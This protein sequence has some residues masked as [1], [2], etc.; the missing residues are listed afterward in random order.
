MASLRMK[1]GLLGMLSEQYR[2]RGYVVRE[3]A[4]VGADGPR[5][6]LL[7][8]KDGEERWVEVV[9]ARDGP[10]ATRTEAMRRWAAERPHRHIDMVV[11]GVERTVTVQPREVLQARLAAL[12]QLMTPATREAACLTTWAV[13]EAVA[14]RALLHDGVVAPRA[15]ILSSLGHWG[16]LDPE[17]IGR[18]RRLQR[19][20]DAVAHGGDEAVDLTEVGWLRGVAE[21]LLRE[22]DAE[23]GEADAA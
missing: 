11:G 5:P 1:D 15:D 7:A 6:D 16:V 19:V 18:L 12:P 8:R 22:T 17:Q 23:G 10:S 13:F 21:A 4:S 3:E 14:R 2:S 20:R 9:G